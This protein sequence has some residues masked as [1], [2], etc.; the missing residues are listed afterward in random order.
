MKKQIRVGVFETNSSSTHSVSIGN[1]EKELLGLY[2]YEEYNLLT[3]QYFEDNYIHVTFGEF[4]WEQKTYNDIITKLEYALTMLVCLQHDAEGIKTIEDFY[5]LPEFQEINQLVANHC[6]CD[7]ILI[8]LSSE[9]EF[10]FKGGYYLEHPGYID[11]QSC[12]DYGCLDDFLN[13]Y[14]VTLEQFIFD[15]NVTLITDNDNH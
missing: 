7:G 14:G 15:P 2:K 6:D 12:E 1:G 4:G 11:H 5:A 3:H 13:R 8:D 10:G 9:A